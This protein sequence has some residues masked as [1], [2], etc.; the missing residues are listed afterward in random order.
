MNKKDFNE[1]K[2][3]YQEALAVIK[4]KHVSGVTT[5]TFKLRRNYNV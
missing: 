2:K 4:G 1:L 5:D 3:G